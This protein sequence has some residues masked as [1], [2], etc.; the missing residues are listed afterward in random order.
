MF[1]WIPGYL[2]YYRLRLAYALESEAYKL[3]GG[4]G[5]A[6]I[7]AKIEAYFIAHMQ[8]TAPEKYHEKLTPKYP[9]S[10]SVCTYD[11]ETVN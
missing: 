3:Q 2:Q 7:R 9:V 6:K 5:P 1:R 11:L 8:A 10:N 4:E